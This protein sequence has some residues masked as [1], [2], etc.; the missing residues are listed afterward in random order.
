MKQKGRLR[1][2]AGRRKRMSD[3]VHQGN[4]GDLRDDTKR[5]RLSGEGYGDV[6][7]GDG[8]EM[9][10]ELKCKQTKRLPQHNFCFVGPVS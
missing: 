4:G 6:E 5:R 2:P 3:L 9:Q 7:D 10:A 8:I 1:T